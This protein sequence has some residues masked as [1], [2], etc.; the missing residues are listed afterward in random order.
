MAYVSGNVGRLTLN[1]RFYG[2]V[3][4]DVEATIDNLRITNSEGITNALGQG[5]GSHA[6]TGGNKVLT[7][8][9]VSASFDPANNPFGLPLSLFEGVFVAAQLF[10]AGLGGVSWYSPSFHIT[11]L[12][13]RVDVNNLAPITIGGESSGAYA[14]PFA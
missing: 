14:I 3:I 8:T 9:I 11:R 5:I 6:S 12:S 7:M 13:Q 1:G 2:F 10:P 4:A